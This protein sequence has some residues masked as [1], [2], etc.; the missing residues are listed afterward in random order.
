M[1]KRA[2]TFEKNEIQWI[3]AV[4]GQDFWQKM[5]LEDAIPQKQ[6]NVSDDLLK[7]YYSA[8]ADLLN[9]K[10]WKDAR[11]AFLFL[12]FLNPNYQNFWLGLGIAEQAMG[13]F[14][15]A[16]I[17]YLL[18]ETIDPT[19]LAVHTN[20]YQCHKAVGNE[21]AAEWSYQKA[22]QAIGENSEFVPVDT[23]QRML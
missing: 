13:S 18:A 10:N 9:E 4:S 7:L 14:N 11:D 12:T 20:T 16:L 19:N 1:P 17:A 23:N 2:E 22:Q 21:V 15:A 5:A 6:L 3:D 8:A